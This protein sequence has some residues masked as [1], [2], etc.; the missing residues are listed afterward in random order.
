[1]G[2]RHG[3][4]FRASTTTYLASQLLVCIGPRPHL[5]ILIAK[6]V[7]W[8]RI[9]SLYGSQTSPVALCMQNVVISTRITSLYGSQ[10]SPVVLCTQK[11]DFWTRITSLYLSQTSPVVLC[12]QKNMI[13]IRI[14]SLYESQPSSVV[15]GCKTGLL[16]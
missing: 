1:M 3:L 9:I 15:F 8:Y 6:N 10:T 11:S 14:T 13:S 7:F 5:W 12:M 4:S 16:D 2:P